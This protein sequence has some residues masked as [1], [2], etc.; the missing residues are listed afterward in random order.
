[1]APDPEVS[2]IV[3][4]YG[5][6]DLVEHQLIEF[7]KDL[8]FRRSAELIYVIDDPRIVDYFDSLTLEFRARYG[9]PFRWVWGHE[10]RGF[11]GANNL[12]AEFARGEYLLFMNSDVIP[13]AP[14][15]LS[16]LTGA[17]DERPSLGAVGP[18]LL[19]PGG[20]IQHAGMRPVWDNWLGIWY[21]QHVMLGFDPAL[22]RNRGLTEVPLITGACLML[23][24]TDF[25]AIG[26]WDTGYLIGDYEDSELC[27]RLRK[28]GM[29]VAYVPEVDLVHLERQSFKGVGDDQFRQ[30]VTH[31]NAV[32]YRDRWNAMLE[33]MAESGAV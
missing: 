5:R 7:S 2:V 29:F 19:F 13:I 14:G 6:T 21:N 24:R 22:D 16:Q 31:L 18:R 20:G 3:P 17:M 4:L 8:D 25:D 32:R 11:A 9:V 10:N 30:K 26:G 28:R 23:R 33:S 27:M 15:W 12:G 1:L